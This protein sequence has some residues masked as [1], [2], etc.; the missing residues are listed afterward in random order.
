M[1]WDEG[2]EMLY[3]VEGAAMMRRMRAGFT[4]A[5]VEAGAATLVTMRGD[6]AMRGGPLGALMATTVGRR[7][8]R[9][10]MRSVL[11]GLRAHVQ[12]Y[13]ASEG[14]P[15]LREGP[16]PGRPNAPNRRAEAA[17]TRVQRNAGRSAG[18]G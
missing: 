16:P 17:A 2:R 10:T 11:A 6:F 15:L 7:K 4:L 14:L 8:L 12:R 18:V 3:E 13:V 1:A 5:P 9:G